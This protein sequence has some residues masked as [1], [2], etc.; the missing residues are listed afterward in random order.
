MANEHTESHKQ[1]GNESTNAKA[2]K[3]KRDNNAV[4][5]QRGWRTII[6]LTKHRIARIQSE[7][8]RE[9]ETRENRKR[10]PLEEHLCMAT[11]TAY[12]KT[13]RQRTTKNDRRRKK[14]NIISFPD[15][16]PIISC[17]RLVHGSEI[18]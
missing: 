5:T 4:W 9:K 8:E 12:Q 13:K 2:K 7:T 18:C 17:C 1:R 14:E 16:Q 11:A 3:R 15:D 6:V 10:T